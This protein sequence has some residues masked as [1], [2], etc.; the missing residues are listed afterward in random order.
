MS[1]GLCFRYLLSS[2]FL[3]FGRTFVRVVFRS[4][5]VS[6]ICLFLLLAMGVLF[7]CM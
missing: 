1:L 7:L 2:V 6:F 3:Y 5:F 4:L